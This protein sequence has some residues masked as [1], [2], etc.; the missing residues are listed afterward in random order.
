MGG[1][2]KGLDV[3]VRSGI[4]SSRKTDLNKA[5]GNRKCVLKHKLDLME[6]ENTFFHLRTESK[7]EAHGGIKARKTATIHVH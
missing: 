1:W 5:Y 4:A 7:E 3:A 6:R 2:K